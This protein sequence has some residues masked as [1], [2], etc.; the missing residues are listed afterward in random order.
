MIN[1]ALFDQKTLFGHHNV[2]VRNVLKIIIGNI[3]AYCRVVVLYRQCRVPCGLACGQYSD[4][5]YPGDMRYVR[6]PG[7]VNMMVHRHRPSVYKVWN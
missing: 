5:G 7:P 1:T 6:D 2:K 4:P 3:R